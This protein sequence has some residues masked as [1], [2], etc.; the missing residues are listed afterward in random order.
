VTFR[1]PLPSTPIVSTSVR[2]SVVCSTN[3]TVFPSA[4]HTASLAVVAVVV[5]AAGTASA[6]AARTPTAVLHAVNVTAAR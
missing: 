3:A 5:A 2:P 1:R 6:A 4:A